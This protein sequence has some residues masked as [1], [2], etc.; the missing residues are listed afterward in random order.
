MATKKEIEKMVY[1]KTRELSSSGLNP[2]EAYEKAV[3]LVAEELAPK[4]IQ[5]IPLGKGD[6][7][8]Y[9][10]GSNLSV[11]FIAKVTPKG[12][13]VRSKMDSNYTFFK[14]AYGLLVLTKAKDLTNG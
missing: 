7:V 14:P 12:A 4:D 13:Q 8:V 6:K 1:A 11:G 10:S 9:I 2:Q 5:K 3:V